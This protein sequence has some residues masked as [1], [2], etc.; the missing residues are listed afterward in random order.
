M[1]KKLKTKFVVLSMT[2]MFL[3]LTLIV[4]GMNILNYNSVVSEADETLS[5]LATNRGVFPDMEGADRNDLPPGLSPE[6]PYEARYFSVLLSENGTV[7][8]VDT[9]RIKAV[10]TRQAIEYATEVLSRNRDRGFSD[11]YRFVRF[12]EG[13]NTRIT[14]LDCGR[15]I[16]AF[17]TFLYSSIAMASVGYVLFF[18]VILFFSGRI[19]RPVAESQEK[20]KRFITDAG[21]EIKTP[22][23]IIQADADVLEME[24]EDNEWLADIQKQTRRLTDLT[25]DLVYLSR[26]EEGSSNLP[27]IEFPFSDVVEEAALSFQALAQTQ[28]KIFHCEI[29]PMLSAVGNE[30]AIRQL[31]SILLDNAL[32]YSPEGGTILLCVRRQGRQLRLSVSNTT[33]S[34]IPKEDLDRLF[35]RFYRLDSSRNTQTGGYGIGLSIAKAITESHSGK[36]FASA[37]D[38]RT[39]E[40]AAQFPT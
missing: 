39:L 8:Q 17:H 14:F 13:A 4:A 23:A 40:I 27:M 36:I 21:H 25:K 31:V 37:K 2:A 28:N 19:I 32:K 9:G 11:N 7:F 22:L 18:A 35:D 6:A 10:G 1:I 5:L 30:K 29:Q 16:D 15:K 12:S 33:A 34:P 24:L 3:L 26:M 20:Q 38:H